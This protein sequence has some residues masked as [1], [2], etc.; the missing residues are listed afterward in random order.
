MTASC[1]TGT[2]KDSGVIG[3]QIATATKLIV[4]TVPNLARTLA[5]RV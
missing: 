3:S 4:D 5:N 2:R 1:R